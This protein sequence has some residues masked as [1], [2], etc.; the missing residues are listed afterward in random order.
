MKKS[1]QVLS[2][3]YNKLEYLYTDSFSIFKSKSNR[4]FFFKKN[5]IVCV[6]SR[7]KESNLSFFISSTAPIKWILIGLSSAIIGIISLIW[8]PYDIAMEERLRMRPGIQ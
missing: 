5:N 2:W 6:R 8:T 1:Q 3:D 7:D 4:T